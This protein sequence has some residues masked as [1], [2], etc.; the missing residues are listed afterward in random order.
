MRKFNYAYND[1][2][3]DREM[4]QV[5]KESATYYSEE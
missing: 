5:A 3:I 1:K 4:Q 2:N